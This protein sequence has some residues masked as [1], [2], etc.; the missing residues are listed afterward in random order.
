MAN[1][2]FVIEHARWDFGQFAATEIVQE[3]GNNEE[4]N[5]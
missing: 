4:N 2:A 3:A 1:F 5:Y